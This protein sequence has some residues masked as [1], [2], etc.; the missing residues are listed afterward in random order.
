MAALAC[1]GGL[2]LYAHGRRH[3]E[4]VP[5]TDLDLARPVGAFTG[6]K[7]AGLEGDRCEALLA[8]AGVRFTRLPDRA[9][10]PS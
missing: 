6:R 5:W 8:R 1:L 2:L 10:A 3:P 9:E 4:D 7:L